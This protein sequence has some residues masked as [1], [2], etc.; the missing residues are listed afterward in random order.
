M[1]NVHI[2]LTDREAGIRYSVH[3]NTIHRW[4]REGRF[5]KPVRLG[6]NCT[7][8]RLTDLERWE[9]ERESA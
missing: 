3:R 7:R 2:Y 5:P 6:E 9:A 8:W 1:D 4:A